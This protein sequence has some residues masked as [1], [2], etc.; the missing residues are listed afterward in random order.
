MKIKEEEGGTQYLDC[1]PVDG[2]TLV[3]EQETV[4]GDITSVTLGIVDNELV[5]TVTYQY[6][7]L[8]VL[9]SSGL[10]SAETVSDGEA[11]TSCP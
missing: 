11:V 7:D 2:L 9:K 3:H 8:E 6:V 4:V 1:D 5:C 10:G